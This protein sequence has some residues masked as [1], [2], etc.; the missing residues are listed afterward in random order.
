MMIRLIL[1]V[2]KSNVVSHSKV[3]VISKCYSVFSVMTLNSEYK[4]NIKSA[5]IYLPTTPLNFENRVKL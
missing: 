3:Q 5:N 2:N 1:N 4:T